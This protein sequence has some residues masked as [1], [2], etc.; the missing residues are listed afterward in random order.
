MKKNRLIIVIALLLVLALLVYAPKLERKKERMDLADS[1]GVSLKDYPP[2]II[3]PTSYFR[4]KLKE[5]MSVDEVHEII[6]GYE[7]VYRCGKVTEIYYFYDT[8]DD[9]AYR[10]AVIYNWDMTY[11]RTV[12]ED[13]NSKY[14]NVEKC[15]LGL[16]TQ[17]DKK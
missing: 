3:F 12:T 1:L 17:E 2:E 9:K 6:Q 7:Q 4:T 14:F 16:L 11:T 15:E 8:E 13:S 5:G 10:Y